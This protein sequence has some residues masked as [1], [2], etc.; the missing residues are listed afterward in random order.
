MH[1]LAAWYV[2]LDGVFRDRVAGSGGAI[3]HLSPEELARWEALAQ[4]ITD[5]WVAET[6]DGA[7][8]LARF[9]ALLAEYRASH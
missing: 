4:P 8:I 6:P 7:A 5:A 3:N 2:R 9:R 1:D